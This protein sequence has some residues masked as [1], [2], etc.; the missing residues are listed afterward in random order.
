MSQ[1]SIASKPLDWIQHRDLLCWAKDSLPIHALVDSGA[2]VN[3]LDQN[4]V[5]QFSIPTIPLA[6]LLIAIFFV[7]GTHMAVPFDSNSL[8]EPS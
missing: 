4:F 3:F 1:T 5:M 2:D 7:Q 6:E 8:W